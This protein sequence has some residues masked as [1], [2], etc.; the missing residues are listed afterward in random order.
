MS[1]FSG[2]FFNLH[3][4]KKSSKFVRNHWLNYL[5]TFVLYALLL[6]AWKILEE[7]SICKF[8]C[9]SSQLD[10]IIISWMMPPWPVID[11]VSGWSECKSILCNWRL[12]NKLDIQRSYPYNG[13]WKICIKYIKRS[14]PC[15][16]EWKCDFFLNMGEKRF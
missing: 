11:L 15:S 7:N 2:I 5:L 13:E 1:V 14:C 4:W 16:G 9:R 8:N 3:W 6:D 12:M 10:S